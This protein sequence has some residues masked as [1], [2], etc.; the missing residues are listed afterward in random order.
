ME[1]M[2]AEPGYCSPGARGLERTKAARHSLCLVE[3]ECVEVHVRTRA[4]N[5]VALVSSCTSASF[6]CLT[7]LMQSVSLKTLLKETVCANLGGGQ[8]DGSVVESF[9]L[10]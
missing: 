2:V 4:G 3:L 5:T 9:L 7:E 1:I 8:S 6:L 10:Y